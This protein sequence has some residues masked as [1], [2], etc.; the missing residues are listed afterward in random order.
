MAS[1]VMT[2]HEGRVNPVNSVRNTARSSNEE[3]SFVPKQ[4]FKNAKDMAYKMNIFLQEKV[5][6]QKYVNILGETVNDKGEGT[7]YRCINAGSGHYSEWDNDTLSYLQ[8]DG[9][10]DYLEFKEKPSK[11]KLDKCAKILKADLAKGGYNVEPKFYVLGHNPYYQTLGTFGVGI[12][13][14]VTKK[15]VKSSSKPSWE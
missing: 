4:Y 7:K 12:S 10:G 1:E 5:G 2:A 3:K 11:E 9:S 13:I 8:A 15:E 6:I 14:K